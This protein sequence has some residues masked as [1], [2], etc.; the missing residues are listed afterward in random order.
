MKNQVCITT[1]TLSILQTSLDQFRVFKAG[2]VLLILGSILPSCILNY[3]W[4]SLL[5]RDHFCG[6]TGPL[7]PIIQFAEWNY[8]KDGKVED[9]DIVN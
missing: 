8:G 9:T 3:A 4:G 5:R 6:R 7:I 1:V 2:S